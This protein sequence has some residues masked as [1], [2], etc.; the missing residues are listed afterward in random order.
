MKVFEIFSE[1][2]TARNLLNHIEEVLNI[3]KQDWNVSIVAFT[4]DASEESRRARA[5]LV[6]KYPS[7]FGPDCYAHQVFVLIINIIF[8][9]NIYFLID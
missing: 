6:K 9:F 5:D 1:S 4:S 2:R 3:L 7:I 8:T